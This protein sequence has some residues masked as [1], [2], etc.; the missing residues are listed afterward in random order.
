MTILGDLNIHFNQIL[1]ENTV[2]NNINNPLSS[3]GPLGD[4]FWDVMPNIN[5]FTKHMQGL[6]LWSI[7]G[8]LGP[9]GALGPLGPLGPVGAHGLAIN[10]NGSYINSRGQIERS[11]SAVYD[12]NNNKTW[13]LFERYLNKDYVQELSKSRDLDTS[14]MVLSETNTFGEEYIMKITEPQFISI[15]LTPVIFSKNFLIEIYLNESL[16]FES[17]ALFYIPWA[18]I[19]I[20]KEMIAKNLE[21][22]VI[23]KTEP[24]TCGLMGLLGC[25][26]Q[27]Y[28]Y[29]VGSTSFMLRRPHIQYSGPYLHDCF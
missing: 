2:L 18:Q 25:K 13:P 9:L 26:L 16:V 5:D 1:G 15:S 19:Y 10:K 27:Y 28:L 20:S 7:L 17:K 6:G 21:L 23:V 8:P 22:K 29:V 24:L 4:S 14:F 12:A 11:I 3:N